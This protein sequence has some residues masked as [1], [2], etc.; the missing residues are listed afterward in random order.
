MIKRQQMV[1]EEHDDRVTKHTPKGWRWI[2]HLNFAEVHI[3]DL[4]TAVMLEEAPNKSVRAVI[5]TAIRE[6]NRR[7]K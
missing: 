7:S 3:S 1:S 4:T 6:Q 2:G 5:S